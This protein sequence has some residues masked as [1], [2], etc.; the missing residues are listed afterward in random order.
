MQFPRPRLARDDD[1]RGHVIVENIY[2]NQ[3]RQKEGGGGGGGGEG[4]KSA[5]GGGGRETTTDSDSTATGSGKM[6]ILRQGRG[7]GGRGNW[8]SPKDGKKWTNEAGDA[9]VDESQKKF[10]WNG[11]P[12]GFYFLPMIFFISFTQFFA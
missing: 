3:W 1:D 9:I 12:K 10:D 5:A 4:D 2:E 8:V 11:C 6:G 7:G